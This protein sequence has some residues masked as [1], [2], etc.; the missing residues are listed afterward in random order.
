[1]NFR[2]RGKA[3]L[4]RLCFILALSPATAQPAPPCP[5]LL[6]LRAEEDYGVLR[7][8][9]LNGWWERAKYL[10]IQKDTY[11]SL[12]GDVRYLTEV[13]RNN[14]WKTGSAAWLLQR[15]ML[16]VDAHR[17]NFRTFLQLRSAHRSFTQLSPRSVDQDRLDVHQLF[18][19]Y[20]AM[21]DVQSQ[22]TITLRVGRQEFWLGARRLVSIREGPNLRRSFDAVRLYLSEPTR[23]VDALY[24]RPVQDQPGF[25]NNRS[26]NQEQLWGV[27]GVL[28]NAVATVNIDL[29]YLGFFSTLREYDQGQAQEIRHSLGTRWWREGPLALNAEFIYQMGSFGSGDIQAY[30]ASLEMAR[31]IEL[32]FRSAVGLKTELISGDRNR[33]D[34]DLQTFN[35]LYPRGAYFGLI[36][37]IGPANLID[38]HPF[39]EL[40]PTKKLNIT[41]DWDFFWRHRTTDGI[42]GPNMELERS[43][44][45]ISGLFTGHQPGMEATYAPTRYW[46]LSVEGSYFVSGFFAQN[47]SHQNILHAAV[48]LQGKF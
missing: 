16:H 19:E 18:A 31:E 26:A 35:A 10:P 7:D 15:Y 13:F 37:L 42:Y 33:G 48:T 1:V 20:T 12:G 24:A 43:G 11:L 34:S 4:L 27:Y 3:M 17:R 29:Y 8:Y 36:A 9:Q 44:M 45:N 39:A 47:G 14:G 5:P 2:V 30:T 41:M 23:R 22:R 38:I 21:S 40:S 46:S 32:P 6:L 28:E 25:F